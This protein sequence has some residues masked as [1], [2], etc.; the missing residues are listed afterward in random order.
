MPSYTSLQDGTNNYS[1]Y[2][3]LGFSQMPLKQHNTHYVDGF[4]SIC[5]YMF[6]PPFRGFGAGSSEDHG[7]I[8]ESSPATISL[9]FLL[10]VPRD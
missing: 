10:L 4:L 2:T 7:Y 6:A 8:S 5:I 3:N 9:L 1:N